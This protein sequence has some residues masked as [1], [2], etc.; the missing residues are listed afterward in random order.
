MSAAWDEYV[1][2]AERHANEVVDCPRCGGA[3]Y[4]D[5]EP[6]SGVPYTCF[7]CGNGEMPVYRWQ[8]EAEMI[9]TC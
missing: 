9:E 6:D 5:I 2:D 4:L 1:A 3:W 8:V 7:Y